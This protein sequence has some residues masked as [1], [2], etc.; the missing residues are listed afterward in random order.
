MVWSPAPLIAKFCKCL[1][2]RKPTKQS[3]HLAGKILD[4]ANQTRDLGVLVT[5][6]LSWETHTEQTCAK[7]NKL[8]GLVKRVCCNIHDIETRHL[9]FCTF[10][11]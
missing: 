6:D 10:D 7:A 3:Y 2:K 4:S 8:L 1:K 5:K 11:R 9:H